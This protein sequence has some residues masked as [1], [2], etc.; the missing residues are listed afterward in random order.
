[1]SGKGLVG[2]IK[3]VGKSVIVCR[4]VRGLCKGSEKGLEVLKE[5]IV[6]IG[7]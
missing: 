5:G 1:V 3:A 4:R 6:G 2:S 7:V